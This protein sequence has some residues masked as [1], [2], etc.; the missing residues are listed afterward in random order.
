M[1]QYEH[2]P[3]YKTTYDLLI[4]LMHVTKDFPREFKYSIGE[5]IQINIVELLVEIYKANS[6]RDKKI[7]IE[8]L[9]EKV[10][11]LNLFLRIAFDLK[12]IPINRYSSF[13]EKTS[14][15]AKQANGWLQS[16]STK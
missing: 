11:F 4:E 2:L 15:I 10:Q 8:A 6:A 13:I 16:I 12:L 1:A 3:I 9:L 14:S 5:K 7:F